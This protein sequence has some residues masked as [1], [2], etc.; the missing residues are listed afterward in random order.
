MYD[1]NDRKGINIMINLKDKAL[2]LSVAITLAGCAVP[3]MLG[4]GATIGTMAYRDK[5]VGGSISD[6]EISL[7]IKNKLYRYSADL[8]AQVGVNVQL[9]DVLLTG[10]VKNEDLSL[11]AE[12]RAWQV[13]GV[14]SVLNNIEV[15]EKAGTA[16]QEIGSVP[17]DSW[18]TTKIKSQ[19]FFNETIKSL[20][21]SIK[22]VNGVVYIMGVGRNQ[23]EVDQVLKVASETA[24]VKKVVN[25]VR[26]VNQPVDEKEMEYADHSGEVEVEDSKE[27]NEGDFSENSMLDQTEN[28]E[29]SNP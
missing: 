13:V 23:K 20:N 15:T 6:S 26:L 8:Y 5:G 16:L 14:K 28:D 19:L 24:S 27:K 29:L 3:V 22:T 12:K 10:S 1:L 9:G 4:G 17:L 7:K 2:F 18:I 11:E 21:F 25:Y